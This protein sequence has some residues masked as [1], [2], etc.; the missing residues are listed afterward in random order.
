MDMVCNSSLWLCLPKMPCY[1][2][3]LDRTYLTNVRHWLKLGKPSLFYLKDCKYSPYPP[4]LKLDKYI[5]HGVAT[6]LVILV[7]LKQRT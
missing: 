4:T 2:V 6:G 3:Y 5:E 1:L 7:E